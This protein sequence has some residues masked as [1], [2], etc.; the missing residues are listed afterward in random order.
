MSWNG[1]G[2]LGSPGEA[3]VFRA[4][5][6]F[7]NLVIERHNATAVVTLSRPDVL[8][9]LD[10]TTLQSLAGAIAALG[11]DPAVRCI[12]LTG[13]GRAFVAGADI[14]QL[15][16]L[17]PRAAR[18]FAEL[19]GRVGEAIAACP[20]P[21]LA[22]VNGFALGGGC[23]LVLCC[24]LAIA[25]TKAKFGQPEVNLG[26]IPGFGGT[27]RLPRL[28]GVNAA[29]YLVLSGELVDAAWAERHGL[30]Q[31][32]VE[33]ERLLPR[34]LEIGDSIAKRGPLAVASAKRVLAEGMDV[35]LA[36][37]LRIEALAFGELFASTDMQEGTRAF[38]DKRPPV[39]TGE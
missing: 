11:R 4:P 32:V 8:N 30:V 15:S 38:L 28:I 12:V 16:T 35:P 10:V 27:Q 33:P 24:D 19:G 13:S 6:D 5:M 21:V 1:T 34:C 3:V 37:G 22:A 23:E 7:P 39:F 2:T 20:K 25:S 9:A 26:L 18:E 14:A 17:G 29:R 36:T 31:E